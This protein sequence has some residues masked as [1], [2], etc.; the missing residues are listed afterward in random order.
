MTDDFEPVD[1]ERLEELVGESPEDAED[2]EL[3]RYLTQFAG[4]MAGE[5]ELKVEVKEGIEQLAV[6]YEQTLN[7]LEV[8]AEERDQYR[9]AAITIADLGTQYLNGDQYALEQMSSTLDDAGYDVDVDHYDTTGVFEAL[10][11][12]EETVNDSV[13]TFRDF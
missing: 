5:R 3:V 13:D 2:E 4:A 8:T 10:N 7:E 1:T 11:D 9:E 6:D 12:L